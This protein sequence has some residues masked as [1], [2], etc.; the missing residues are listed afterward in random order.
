MLRRLGIVC[1]LLAGLI[2]PLPTNVGAETPTPFEFLEQVYTPE[3]ITAGGPVEIAWAVSNALMAYTAVVPY[4]PNTFPECAGQP[5]CV[6]IRQSWWEAPGFLPET[7]YLRVIMAHEWAHV[8]SRKRSFTEP[9][10]RTTVGR[11]D[12]E[13]LADAVAATVL[14]RGGFPGAVTDTYVAQY[15]CDDYWIRRYGHQAAPMWRA[16]TYALAQDLLQWSVDG[17][18]RPI[19]VGPA[20]AT[21]PARRG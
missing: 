11:V 3:E 5:I 16:A 9:T 8:L 7:D 1:A 15:S 18:H 12:E 17:L 10:W 2:L 14:A 4:Y 6:V 20:I 19:Y 13:C 21:A